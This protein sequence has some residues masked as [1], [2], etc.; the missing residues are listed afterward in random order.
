MDNGLTN[1]QIRG[2][3]LPHHSLS[4]QTVSAQISKGLVSFWPVRDNL[5]ANSVVSLGLPL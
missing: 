5:G 3:F 1:S 4:T 2:M